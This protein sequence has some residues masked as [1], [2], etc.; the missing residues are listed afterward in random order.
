[1]DYG[2][3]GLSSDGPGLGGAAWQDLVDSGFVIELRSFF[4]SDFPGI[5]AQKVR[6]RLFTASLLMWIGALVAVSDH[7]RSW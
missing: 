7:P 3:H 5:F 2:H 6:R 1:M 4:L